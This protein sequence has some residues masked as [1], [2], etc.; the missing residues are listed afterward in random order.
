MEIEELYTRENLMELL[1]KSAAYLDTVLDFKIPAHNLAFE[2]SPSHVRPATDPGGL[3]LS[4]LRHPLGTP[5]LREM[6]WPG[7][8]VLIIADDNTR[9]TPARL[10]LPILLDE[11]NAGGVQDG[12]IAVLVS[13]GTHRHMTPEELTAKFGKDMQSRVPI[14]LHRYKDAGELVS[15]GRTRRG[16]EIEINRLLFEVD[17]R[18]ALGDIIPHYPAGWSG[19]AKAVLPGVAGEKT[20]SAL[21]Y[22]GCRYPDI[23]GVETEMRREMEEVARVCK[24]DFIVNTILNRRGELV[25]LVAGDMVAAHRAGVEKSKGIYGVPVSEAVDLCISSAT[26]V[27]FDL[28]QAAKGICAADRVTRRGGE[29]ALLSGCVEGIS[30]AH[31][32]LADYLG[33]LSTSQL[34]ELAEAGS[35]PDPLT[36]AGA[37]L[38]NLIRDK[39]NITLVTEGIPP[40]TCSRLGLGHVWPHQFPDYLQRKIADQPELRVGILNCSAELFPFLTG[41]D[42]YSSEMPAIE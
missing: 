10:I 29:I 42:S 6:L 21:H 13:S 15:L 5:P 33:Q 38:I 9:R 26:P 4:V 1:S 19:G 11:L 14:L 34:W 18:I 30:P 22:L 17:F 23:T 3:I 2:I 16:T 40:E 32:E 7:Q 8:R 24:L 41:P 28:F 35:P 31:P 37:I 36:C 20:T 25:E 39:V 12:D 27:D